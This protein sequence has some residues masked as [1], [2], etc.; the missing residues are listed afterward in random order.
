MMGQNIQEKTSNEVV[1][2]QGD[3][4]QYSITVRDGQVDGSFSSADITGLQTTA[5]Q[6]VTLGLTVDQK[7]NSLFFKG[8]ID[9]T[10]QLTQLLK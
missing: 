9:N 6:L 1:S 8:K 7:D 5:K 4:N 2:L 10:E 3:A